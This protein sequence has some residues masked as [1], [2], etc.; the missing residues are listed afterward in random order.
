[1]YLFGAIA[2]SSSTR[3]F[4]FFTPD[5]N[6]GGGFDSTLEGSPNNIMKQ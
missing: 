1:M 2:L 6:M 4:I 5:I 3:G